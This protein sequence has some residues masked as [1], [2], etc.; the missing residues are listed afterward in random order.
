[1][2]LPVTKSHVSED[3]IKSWLDARGCEIIREERDRMFVKIN[4]PC[5]HLVKSEEGF[6]CDIYEN[7]PSG[8]E[9]FDGRGFD[10]LDCKWKDDRF[11]ILVK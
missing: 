7:R 3:L 6:S 10:F 1:M 11:V 8:C 2:V 9:I 4:T 5:P